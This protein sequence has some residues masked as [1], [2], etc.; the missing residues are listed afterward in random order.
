[1]HCHAASSLLGTVEKVIEPMIPGDA[2]KVEISIQIGHSRQS[3]RTMLSNELCT[4]S[5]VSP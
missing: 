1:M 3:C 4:C 2:E 5:P